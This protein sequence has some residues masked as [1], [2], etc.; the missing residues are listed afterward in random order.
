MD[1]AVKAVLVEARGLVVKGWKRDENARDGPPGGW[2]LPIRRPS[3]GVPRG[4]PAGRRGST[5]EP[6]GELPCLMLTN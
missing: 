3:A 2:C 1:Q 6:E 4:D 5:K